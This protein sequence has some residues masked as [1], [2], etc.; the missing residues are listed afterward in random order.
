MTSRRDFLKSATGS[1]V[2]AG[3]LPALAHASIA[4]TRPMPRKSLELLVLGGTG[5]IGPHLVRYAV[6]RGHHVTIFT[7]GRHDAELPAEVVRLQGDRNGQL[8]SLKG[9]RWDV[10]IDDSANNPEWVALSTELLKDSGA[11]LFVSSTGAYYPYL[12]RGLDE[13]VAVHTDLKDPKDGSETFGVAKA[14]A[15]AQTMKVFGDRGIVIRPTYIVGPGDTSDRFPYWPV[16]LA[17]G[18][19]VLAPGH[20]DDP[21]QIIDVRDLAEFMIRVSEGDRRG[22]FNVAGPKQPLLTRAFYEEAAKVINP[23]VKYTFVD[24]YDFLVAH[25]ID[26]AIPWALLKGNDYGMMSVK[27]DRAIAAGLTFRTLATTLRD[28]LAWW[29]TVPQARRDKPRFTITPE[30]EA[31]ALADWKARKS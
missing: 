2:L 3:S 16:R 8:D 17:R 27:N 12:S 7:R 4:A 14:K 5:F 1:L 20:A 22:I 19:E 30:I 6:A 18:G 10:V 13:S 31:A 21:M 23:S 15:E 11:Y 28:T 26:E 24:D 9:R 25:R 29:P